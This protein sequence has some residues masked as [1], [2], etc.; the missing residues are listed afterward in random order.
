MKVGAYRHEY[1]WSEDLDLFL[2][3]AEVGRLENLPDV[4]VKYRIH[5]GSTNWRNHRIQANNKPKMIAEAYRRRGLTPPTEIEF[6]RPWEE[7]AAKRYVYWVWCALKDRNVFGARKHAW[8]ALKVA[9]LSMETWRAAYC[10][11]RGR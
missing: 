7:P 2:R 8:S 6:T 1:P 9:P 3:M 5:P 10:A 11:L 4:L